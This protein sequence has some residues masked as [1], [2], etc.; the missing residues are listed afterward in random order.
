MSN[1][2]NANLTNY[3]SSFDVNVSL[4]LTKKIWYAQIKYI[5]KKILISLE[6]LFVITNKS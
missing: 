6:L 5:H 2:E 1:F 4:I 3:T